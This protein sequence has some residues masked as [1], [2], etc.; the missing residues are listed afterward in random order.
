MGVEAI[1][2][3]PAASSS[4]NTDNPWPGLLAFR[5]ADQEYFQGRKAETM[6]LFRLV[7]REQLSLLFGLSGLGKSS[8]LQAGLFPMLRR[9]TVFPVYIRLDFSAPVP[10]LVNEVRGR[11]ANEALA[12]QIEAPQAKPDETLWEYFHRLDN[13]FWNSRNRLVMPLLVFDQFEEIFTLGSVDPNRAQATGTLVE[14]LAD[15]AEGRPPARLKARLDEHP[16]ET[17]QF[18][19]SRHHYKIL[20]SIREDFLPDLEALRTRMPALALNRLRLRRMNGEAAMLVVN[21]ARHLIDP[22]VAEQVVRFVAADRQGLPFADLDVEPALLS[23]V[24]RELNNRRRK[25]GELKITAG[26]LAGSH[27]QVLTD[28]YEQSVA[29]LPIEVRRFIE[30]HLLTVSGYRDSVALDNALQEPGVTRQSIERLVERRLVRREDRGGVQRLEL[31]HDLLTG[32]V[33]SSRDRR[34]QVEAAEKERRAL[35]EAQEEERRQ[36]ELRDLKRTRIAAV[37]FLILSV[38]AVGAA[39]WAIINRAA[40]ENARRAAERATLEEKD[41][42]SEAERQRKRAESAVEMIQRSLL[43]RQ[44]ALSGDQ[45]SLSNLVSSLDQNSIIRFAAKASDLGYKNPSNQQVYK[46]EL[47]PEPGT[48]PT[49]REA[50]AF[51]TYLA[52]HPTFQNTLMTAG[53]ERQFRASYIGWGCL[54]RI[55][56]LVEYKDPTRPP[57]VAEFDM[58]ER[59]GW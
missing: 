51:I 2:S 9:E 47:Y 24:C 14:Q 32:V 27:E 29:D 23:V 54:R 52:N 16:D 28:L 31:T 25:L 39:S 37:L 33:R 17:R 45:E 26:L 34:L 42:R 50:V 8:L 13:D 56:G 38:A 10:D 20:L 53:P 41:A 48:L 21:Q 3:A 44:A 11:I 18:S 19:F 4:V 5:E 57:T 12:A 36:R 30:D 49:G 6:E 43:I 40:A 46:F 35:E 1:S 55:V 59:L 58:C 22:F 7:M 15:L